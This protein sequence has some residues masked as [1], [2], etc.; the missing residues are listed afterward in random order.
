[1]IAAFPHSPVEDEDVTDGGYSSLRFRLFVVLYILRTATT[2]RQ[3]SFIFGWGESTIHNWFHVI[4]PI[5]GTALS[6]FRAFP[7]AAQQR[8]MALEHLFYLRSMGRSHDMYNA[9]MNFDRKG[10]Q[11]TRVFA[12]AMGAIDGTFTIWCRFGEDIQEAM[13]TGYKKIHAYKLV[14]LC[15][16]FTKCVL[17]IIVRPATVSDSLA[18]TLAS[19]LHASMLKTSQLLGDDA[20]KSLSDVITPFTNAHI[21]GIKKYNLERADHMRQF[22]FEHSS[23][24]MSSEHVI[25]TLKCWGFLRGTSK[26]HLTTSEEFFRQGVEAIHAIVNADICDFNVDRLYVHVAAE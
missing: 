25:R 10:N 23:N 26:Y 3:C 12:G 21:A 1:L 7:S 22:N 17:A 20:F 2:L 11:P 18:W 5:I 13:Y 14:V 9:R 15:S 19:A 6:P 24:R 4:V 8:D 16:L